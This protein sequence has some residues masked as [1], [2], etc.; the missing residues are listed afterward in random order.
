MASKWEDIGIQL[1]IETGTLESLK[2]AGIDADKALP[3]MLT[4][5]ENGYPPRTVRDLYSA[6][7]SAPVGEKVLAETLLKKYTD[8]GRHLPVPQRLINAHPLYYCSGLI[9][10]YA[11]MHVDQRHIF[12]WG[13]H[14][15]VGW[16]GVCMLHPH[17]HLPLLFCHDALHAQTNLFFS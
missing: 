12:Q 13:R 9:Y 14:I 11:S 17:P 3:K 10:M 6:L 1:D 16:G 8:Q 7:S 4:K 2:P 15:G 5:V